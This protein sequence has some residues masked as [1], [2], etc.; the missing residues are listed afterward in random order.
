MNLDKI[1]KITTYFIGITILA[2]AVYDIF[3][4]YS[5]GTEA[6]ISHIMIEWSYKYPSFTFLMGF[7]MGHLFWR[8]R[9][10]KIT[11][12]LGK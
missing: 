5:G 3:A 6:S 8:M 11:A 7:T 9:D 10:T 4:I 2:I 1:R 12:P